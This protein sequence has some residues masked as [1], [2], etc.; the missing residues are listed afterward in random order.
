MDA[1]EKA[2][3]AGVVRNLLSQKWPQSVPPLAAGEELFRT[4]VSEFNRLLPGGGVPRGQWVEITG[5]PGSGKTGLLFAL[6]AGCA[7]DD[8]I[9]YLDLPRQF[10]PA[11][12]QAAGM[13]LARLH[14]LAPAGP[15]PA[16]RAAEALLT[17]RRTRVVVFDVTGQNAPW[18][19]ALVHRLRQETLRSG[20]LLFLLSEPSQQVVPPSIVAL[21]VG[22]ERQNAC[23]ILR[24]LK[25]RLGGEGAQQ[26]WPGVR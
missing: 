21:R 26:A 4:G 1:Q 24:V 14:W 20:A 10:F 18:P 25:S 23:C 16:L 3:G 17:Q 8:P 11:A 2:S 6:L 12:A 5:L 22:V 13:P 15:G 7:A 9:A 19:Q